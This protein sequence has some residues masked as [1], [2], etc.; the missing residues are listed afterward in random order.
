MVINRVPHQMALY[1]LFLIIV[2]IDFSLIF[3]KRA[4][5]SYVCPIGHLLGL[6]AL[7]SPFEWR[8][9]DLSVCKNCETKDCISKKNNYRLTSR[10]CTSNLYPAAISDNLECLLCTQC[11]K[12]CPNK[13]I[14]FSL[15]RPF[16][17]FFSDINL[18]P[19]Q[20]GFITLL[21]AFV[22]Y[23]ILSEWPVSFDIIMRVPDYC[24]SAL[25]LTGAMASFVWAAAT[26]IVLPVILLLIFGVLAKL[27]SGWKRVPF[28]SVIKTFVLLLLPTIAGAHIIKSLL[29]VSSQIPYWRNAISD[30]KGMKTAQQI[31]EGSLVL[32][33]SFANSLGPIVSIASAIILLISIAATMWIF[34]QSANVQKHPAGMKFI[35]LLS[36][37]TYWTIF[38]LTISNWKFG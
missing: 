27:A 30:P 35:L 20:I 21:G 15:R 17:D 8:I 37:L 7:I 26:F 34:C 14:R 18:Q 12:V 32:D 28:W 1:M 19:A 4:F 38:G 33:N 22:V 2:A 5:C 10:S 36:V 24:I 16:T 31:I 29:K 9:C 23:E 13:N 6:Y 25:G 3:Q 11:L